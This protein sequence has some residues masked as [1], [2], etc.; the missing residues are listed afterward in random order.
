MVRRYVVL[1]SA[2]RVDGFSHL[3]RS[4]VTK[5]T[6]QTLKLDDFIINL[7]MYIFFGSAI[8]HCKK[9]FDEE[10]MIRFGW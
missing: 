4:E 6:P 3:G 1:G 2:A 10:I 5:P 9:E 7:R 8:F